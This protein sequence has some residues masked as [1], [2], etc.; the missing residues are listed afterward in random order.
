MIKYGK[1]IEYNGSSGQIICSEGYKYIL[2]EQNVLYNNPK[3]GDLIS[4]K[5]EIY[6]TPEIEERVA[7]FVKK[8]EEK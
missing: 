8:I 3:L 6:K 1:I 7:T 2:L 4:F 5:E